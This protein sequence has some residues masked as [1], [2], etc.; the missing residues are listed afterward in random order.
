MNNLCSAWKFG[1]TCLAFALTSFLFTSVSYAS[2]G[3]QP[4]DLLVAL[5]DGTVQVRAADGTLQ[6]ILTG[7]IQGQAKGLAINADGDLLVSHWQVNGNLTVGNAVAKFHPDGSFAGAFGSGYFC[8]PS[9]IAIGSNGFVFVGQANCSGKIVKLDSSG[10]I[11]QSFAPIIEVGGA[12]WID[13]AD[14][15]CT[16]YYTSAGQLVHRF[17]VCVSAQ[18]PDLSS[19][20]LS[21]GA[22]LGLRIMPDG[23]V[24]VAAQND[25]ERLNAS[26]QVIAKYQ[27]VAET[28]F[29]GIF[30]LDDG[31]SFWAS[32]YVTGNVYRFD[33]STGQILMSFNNGVAGTGAKGVIIVPNAKGPNPP[34]PQ[35]PPSQ[36]TTV[37]GRM[38]GGGDFKAADGTIVHDGFELRCDIRSRHQN[39]EVNWGQGE[40]FHLEDVTAVQC[41]DNPAIDPGH[42]DAPF[43]TMTLSGTGKYDGKNGA[44]IQLLFSDAGE[45][46]T[47]DGVAMVIKDDKGN[48]VLNVPLTTLIGGNNQAHRSNGKDSDD[49]NGDEGNGKGNGKGNGQGDDDDNGKGKDHDD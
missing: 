32:S 48:V 39:L 30:V 29:V 45:P 7:P 1:S 49:D 21:G 40:K 8:D 20:P 9:G 24:I 2:T 36:L 38:T 11:V 10:N 34:P 42:P 17:D 18:L 44:T 46:G 33:I 12:R 35:P 3:F 27:A 13:L 25:V 28:G 22:A 41:F 37:K 5:T 43:D 47:H 26:G 4:G 15:G 14:D 19:V 31:K 6:S 16:M 23:G